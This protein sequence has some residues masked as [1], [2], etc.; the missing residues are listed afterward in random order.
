MDARLDSERGSVLIVVLWALAI[1]ALALTEALAVINSGAVLG[2]SFARDF[3]DE[4]QAQSALEI[5]AG[6]LLTAYPDQRWVGDGTSNVLSAN[7]QRTI[8]RVWDCTALLDVNRAD[9][10]LMR[11]LFRRFAHSRAAADDAVALIERA[12]G[13]IEFI[14]NDAGG[15][16]GFETS[17]SHDV[18][19]AHPIRS[20]AFL[21]RLLSS[22][23]GLVQNV[24]PLLTV[25]GHTGSINPALAPR[26]LIEAVPD[27][28]GQEAAAIVA[29]RDGGRVQ[30]EDAQALVTKYARYF[31]SQSNDIYRV[32]IAGSAHVT[33]ATILLDRTGN[34]PYHVLAW[35]DAL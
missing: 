21:A 5:A 7:G 20:D 31:S 19:P 30:S 14:A 6:R 32:D 35:R 22:D 28:S 23:A 12:R 15:S 33:A 9:P 17:E 10:D 25:F 13:D 24:L 8:I 16:V 27:I 18:Q 3:V 26:A 29:G 11:N 1:L 34:A 4:G 2:R